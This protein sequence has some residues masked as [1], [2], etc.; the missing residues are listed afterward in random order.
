MEDG[1]NGF[2]T[3]VKACVVLML[4]VPLSATINEIKLVVLALATDGRHENAPLELFK[5]ALPG[6]LN[7][8]KVRVCGG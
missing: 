3:I 6:P 7:K 4:G 2:T 5:V 8:L 1:V